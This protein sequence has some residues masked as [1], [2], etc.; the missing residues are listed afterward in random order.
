[1]ADRVFGFSPELLLNRFFDP[2][3]T[4]MRKVDDGGK[5]REENNNVYSG[6]SMPVDRL[7]FD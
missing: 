4:S 6:S 1:M 7:K 5:K 2:S 3:T